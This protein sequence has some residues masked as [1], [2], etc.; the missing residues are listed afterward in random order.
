M[1]IEKPHNNGAVVGRA[2]VPG[3]TA[4][5]LSSFSDQEL[6]AMIEAVLEDEPRI[7]ARVKFSAEQVTQIIAI[8]CEAPIA[9][10][11]SYQSMECLGIG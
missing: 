5:E 1:C 6:Q 9:S 2:A 7:G 11:A 4:A 8:A 10:Q 3:I